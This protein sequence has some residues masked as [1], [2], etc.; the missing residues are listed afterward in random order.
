[1]NNFDLCANWLPD[2]DRGRS[3]QAK[4]LEKTAITIRKKHSTENL[5]GL[6]V[7]VQSLRE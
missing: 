6:T 1:V 2:M 3:A 4:P 7:D 5:I